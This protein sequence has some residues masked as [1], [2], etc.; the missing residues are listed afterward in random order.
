M[1]YATVHAAQ[2]LQPLSGLEMVYA[3]KGMEGWG[4]PALGAMSLVDIDVSG[5]RVGRVPGWGLL[6]WSAG[7]RVLPAPLPCPARPGQSEDSLAGPSLFGVNMVERN[8]HQPINAMR[9]C[10][11]H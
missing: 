2:Q 1:V 6:R 10:I 5:H 4:R 9:Y 7:S 8:R 3:T 11:A